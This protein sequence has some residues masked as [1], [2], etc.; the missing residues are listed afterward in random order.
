MLLAEALLKK[1]VLK[2]EL[3]ALE[4]RMSES[5]RIPHDEE[6]VDDYTLLLIIYREKESELFDM[7]LRI[8]ATN[9]ITE[10]REGETISQAIIK[11][12]GLKRVVS[13]YSKLLNAAIGS[14]R[15]YYGS[16]DVKYIRV[17]DMDKVRSDM[18]SAAQQYREL[19][20]KLQQLNWNTELI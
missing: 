14:N 19:D 9:N 2:K 4:Q 12:D 8:L 18:D 7:N 3:D 5:A 6:P 15:G 13:M 10:I 1:A 20:V 16:R 11:R 17:I